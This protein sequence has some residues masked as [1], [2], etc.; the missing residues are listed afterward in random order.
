MNTYPP[1]PAGRIVAGGLATAAPWIVSTSHRLRYLQLLSS[2]MQLSNAPRNLL[3][4]T[5]THGS[6]CS[7]D[8]QC[9]RVGSGTACFAKEGSSPRVRRTAG[10]ESTKD[11]QL[12]VYACSSTSI[13]APVPSAEQRHCVGFHCI[14]CS[15]PGEMIGDV[16]QDGL[17]DGKEAGRQR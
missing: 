17:A 8:Q 5:S 14:D 3:A 16:S 9:P 11:A 12:G 6:R 1:A 4:R 2:Q 15:P 10:C 7:S 13:P